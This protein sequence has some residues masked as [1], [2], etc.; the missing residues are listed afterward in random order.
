[1]SL[2][3][4]IHGEPV[5]K[6]G[7]KIGVNRKSGK[8]F[9]IKKDGMEEVEKSYIYQI[10]QQLPRGFVKLDGPIFVVVQFF[11]EPPKS[12][13]KKLLELVKEGQKVYKITKPDAHDNLMKLPMDCLQ[14]HVLT[15]D[16][17]ICNVEIEKLYSM[18]PR[19][20]IILNSPQINYF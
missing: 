2:S 12:M 8:A 4:I 18:K 16:S 20:V 11:F 1:M 6:Q 15:N 3:L 7:F 5:P 9:A 19:T 14:Q 17:R 13:P 10:R